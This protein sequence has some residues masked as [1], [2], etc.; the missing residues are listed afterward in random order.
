MELPQNNA[1]ATANSPMSAKIPKA[2]LN[3]ITAHIAETLSAFAVSSCLQ[4]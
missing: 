4:G 1:L 2:R 3:A